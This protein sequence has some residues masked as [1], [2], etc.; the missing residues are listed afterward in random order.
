VPA[1]PLL[2]RLREIVTAVIAFIVVLGFAAM[3]IVAFLQLD[4]TRVDRAK[5]LL[6]F[7]NPLVG[8]VIG[9]YF[10]RTTSEARA[11][12]AEQTAVTADQAAVEARKAQQT[13]DFQ[14]RD[15]QAA[16]ET[17]KAHL[18]NLTTAAERMLTETPQGSGVL[19]G[20]ETAPSEL[21]DAMADLR[22]AVAG[23]KRVLGQT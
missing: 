22:A 14:A 13:A 9:F 21:Q 3:I 1:D 15:A 4:D 10:N 16:K 12:Q 20:K 2:R 6:A 23:A 19:G 7:V 5:D 17:A 8:V 18:S 11:E